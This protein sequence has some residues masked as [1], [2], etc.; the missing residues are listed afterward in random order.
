MNSAPVVVM[1]RERRRWQMADTRA[2]AKRTSAEAARDAGETFRMP[3]VD[4][5]ET[6]DSV[7]LLADM[8]GVGEKGVQV[9][10]EEDMLSITGRVEA[11]RAQDASLVYSEYAALP[12]RRVFV[13]SYDIRRDGIEGKMHNGVL[14]LVLPKA[15]GAKAR[16]I[17]IKT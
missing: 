6:A 13:L 7:I 17:P 3:P 9:S 1:A 15:E 12:F 14:R 5:V 16:K 8:P 2:V 10:V 11:A 4:I